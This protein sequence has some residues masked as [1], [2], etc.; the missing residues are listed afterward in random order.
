MR[1]RL[2]TTRGVT[3]VALGLAA[4]LTFSGGAHLTNAQQSDAGRGI[5]PSVASGTLLTSGTTESTFGGMRTLGSIQLS[6]AVLTSASNESTTNGAVRSLNPGTL[7]QISVSGPSVESGNSIIRTLGP[8]VTGNALHSAATES[9]SNGSVRTLSSASVANARLSSTANSVNAS[10]PTLTGRNL[11]SDALYRYVASDLALQD[12]QTDTND[13]GL[14]P[15]ALTGQS[16]QGPAV[17]STNSGNGRSLSAVSLT[18]ISLK[19]PAVE[20]TSGGSGRSLSPGAMTNSRL[21]SASNE[22]AGSGGVRSLGPQN[23]S[24]AVDGPANS[25]G[26]QSTSSLSPFS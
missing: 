16:L 4:A 13:R 22:S 20:S 11:T 15:A 2:L 21:T 25:V 6:G 19:G 3:V 18:G 26:G 10:I 24:N 17:E 5:D 12:D 23:V 14:D 7:I 1:K 8:A 9:T